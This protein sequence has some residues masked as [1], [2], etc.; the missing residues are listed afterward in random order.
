[1][2]TI[3][4]VDDQSS[5]RQGLRME[6]ALEPDS[7]VIAEAENGQEALEL[8]RRLQPDV[9]LMDVKLPMMD[10]IT[11]TEKLRTIAP[12]CAV[13]ILSL[14]DDARTRERA[15]AAGAVAFVSKQEPS[16]AL[17]AAIRQAVARSTEH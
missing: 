2:I 9:I 4:L 16:E 14:Y 5:V 13:V 15:Q 11:T 1:M 3:L 7:Q 12:G 17:L 8:A 6:L 10:G